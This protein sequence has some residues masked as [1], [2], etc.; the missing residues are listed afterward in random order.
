MLQKIKTWKNKKWKLYLYYNGMLVKKV[1]IHEQEA[2]SHNSYVVRVWG[3]KN[4]FGS[5]K[6]TVILR[7]VELL[8]NDDKNLKTHWGAIFERGVDMNE[9]ND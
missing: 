2:P 8:K 6:V 7:P 1:R 3:K 4:I 9:W 5:N